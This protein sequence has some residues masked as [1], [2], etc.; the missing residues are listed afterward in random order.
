MK[1]TMTSSECLTGTD[2]VCEIARKIDREII[3]NVQGDEPLINPKDILT[4]LEAARRN[5]GTIINGMCS[6]EEEND[7]RNPNVPKV[8]TSPDGRLLYM[9][10]APIPTG[11]KLEFKGAMRQVC[12]YAFP[13]NVLR[14]FGRKREKTRV[15]NIE[16]IEILRFLELGHTV[17]MV[18]VKGSPVAVDTPEDLERA[19]KLINV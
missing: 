14:E 4:V 8:V 7:F 16:D 5:K 17:H 9:S 6:I 12:I 1:A 15:E 3:I 19:K 18:E 11:K 10:R 13:K 2:R